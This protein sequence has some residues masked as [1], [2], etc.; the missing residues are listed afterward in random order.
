MCIYAH[1]CKS[2]IIMNRALDPRHVCI[3]KHGLQIVPKFNNVKRLKDHDK[4]E[5]KYLYKIIFKVVLHS[6]IFRNY[7]Q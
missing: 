2:G 6:A 7:I 4:V 5:K 1:V 3:R